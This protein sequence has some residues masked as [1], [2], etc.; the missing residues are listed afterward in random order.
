MNEAVLE[1]FGGNE[2]LALGTLGS[3]AVA[4]VALMAALTLAVSGRGGGA[5]EIDVDGKVK[6][7]IDGDAY[8]RAADDLRGALRLLD[9][10]KSMVPPFFVE[11]FRACVTGAMNELGIAKKS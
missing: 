11:R 1:F 4:L 2:Y 3:L 5:K 8:E 6:A 7:E 9:Q 10:V